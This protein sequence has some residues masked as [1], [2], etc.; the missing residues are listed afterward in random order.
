MT[1]SGIVNATQKTSTGSVP[2]ANQ[3]S[4]LLIR[5]IHAGILPDGERLPPERQMATRLGIAV[6]TLRKALA[7]L[8]QQGLLHRVQGSGNYIHNKPDAD[9]V[10]ALFRLEL[11]SGPATPSASL[12]SVRCMNKAAYVP[13]IGDDKQAFRFRRIRKLD[14]MHA[15]LEEIWLDGRY[16]PSIDPKSVPDSLYQYYRDQLGI[17][18]TRAEDRVSVAQLPSW[19]PVSFSSR[20]AKAWGF[21][22]RISRDHNG[23]LAEYSRTWFDPEHVRFVAR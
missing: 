8:E 1:A 3:I 7:L 20:S 5:E 6:G 2:L 14:Q 22:E 21:I 13:D 9:N 16:A 11:V 23:L 4:E 19:A 17:R 12:I 18:I 15:A 10:Y